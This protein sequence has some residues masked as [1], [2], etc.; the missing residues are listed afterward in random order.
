MLLKN[1]FD[2]KSN[3]IFICGPVNKDEHVRY[4]EHEKIEKRLKELGYL[5]FNPLKYVDAKDFKKRFAFLSMCEKIVT[6]KDWE[7]NE[8]CLK[9]VQVAR[10]QGKEVMMSDKYFFLDN[11]FHG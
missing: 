5:C 7:F 6:I 8:Q 9:E 2:I 3:T 10:L 11:V 4:F 1:P